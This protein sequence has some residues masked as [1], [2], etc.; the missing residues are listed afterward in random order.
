MTMERHLSS[1]LAVEVKMRQS[2]IERVF[3]EHCPQSR[4]AVRSSDQAKPNQI[5]IE[6]AAAFF[7]LQVVPTFPRRT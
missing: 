6:S 2:D 4:P 3:T 5:D 1:R 7:Q